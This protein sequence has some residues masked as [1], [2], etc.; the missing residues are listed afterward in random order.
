MP[1]II[2]VFSSKK[3]RKERNKF[4]FISINETANGTEKKQKTTE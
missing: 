2:D 4:I 3:K 1:F